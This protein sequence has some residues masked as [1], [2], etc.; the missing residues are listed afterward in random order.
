MDTIKIPDKKGVK[1]IAHRG[2]SGLERENTNAAFV[3]AGNR[4]YYGIETD[5]HKTLDGKYV[6]IHDDTTGRVAI[7][8]M[9]VELSTYDT[10]RS[11]TL[12]DLD[13]KKSRSDLKIPNLAEYIAINKKYGKYAVLELKNALSEEE[14]YDVCA[15]IE[16]LDYLHATIFISFC[17][18]NL[19]NLRKKY[20]TQA[21]QFLISKYD[22]TLIARLKE[23]NLDLDIKHTA[24]TAENTAAL[25]A[26]GITV[27]CWTVDNPERAAELIEFGV[28]MIT[29]NILE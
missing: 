20:P 29:T 9:T 8:N 23:H 4:S 18:D 27:N 15:Q 13:G 2:V 16:A 22:D 28:D 26:A 14:I 21:A 17:F 11:L 6:A 7:D 12:V 5:I 1:F 3:A 10:L 24:L 25:K 19:V